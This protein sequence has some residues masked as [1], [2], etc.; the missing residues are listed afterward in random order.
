MKLGA[1][2]CPDCGNLYS[3][4]SGGSIGVACRVGGCEAGYATSN[5]PAF[6]ADVS[7]YTCYV[8]R[9]PD[10][11]MRAIAWLG[12]RFNIPAAQ[13]KNYRD[14]SALPLITRKASELFYLRSE[15]EE[16]GIQIRIE[17]EF[18]YSQDDIEPDGER[19]LTDDELQVMCELIDIERNPQNPQGEQVSGGNGGQRL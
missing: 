12:N 14:D 13:V 8:E 19:P 18:R 7:D 3:F 15:F 2:N 5:P 1:D 10:D 6:A 11:W 9:L 4:V 17:P 16:H